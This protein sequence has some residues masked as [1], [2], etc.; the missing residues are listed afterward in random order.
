MIKI[1]KQLTN[2]FVFFIAMIAI[3]SF[4]I[5]G[6]ENLLIGIGSVSIAITMI[7]QN[8]KSNKI[9]TFINLSVIQ[10][11]FNIAVK[12]SILIATSIFIVNYFNI[13]EGKWIVLTI[14]ILLLPYAEQS[15]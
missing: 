5:F 8:Y 9:Q 10:L 12:A 4:L 14:S 15:R 7:G 1:K 3:S 6:K 2:I 11:I 13:Y